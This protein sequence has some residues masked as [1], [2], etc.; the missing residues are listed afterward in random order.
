MNFF[1]CNKE[2]PLTHVP[3]AN[4]TAH[5]LL[6]WRNG[7]HL[8]RVQWFHCFT[9]Y[10][11]LKC[12]SFVCNRGIKCSIPASEDYPGWKSGSSV[13]LIM[14]SVRRE[15]KVCTRSNCLLQETH[16]HHG[17][18]EGETDDSDSVKLSPEGTS[19]SLACASRDFHEYRKIWTPRINQQLI[20]KPESGNLLAT[21]IYA[22]GLFTKIR[23]K[24]EPH[25]H[26]LDIC[27]ERFPDFASS[28]L[29]TGRYRINCV[30]LLNF[31]ELRY[32]K[33]AWRFPLP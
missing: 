8:R 1:S 26:W 16:D 14:W 4:T 31:V 25:Y 6:Y 33:E 9:K 12:K 24:I 21:H 28:F 23:G 19:F 29:N 7:G 22:V 20:V 13:A 11:C 10:T 5:W 3:K 30:W 15:R 32:H 2:D 27:L 18:L 17:F